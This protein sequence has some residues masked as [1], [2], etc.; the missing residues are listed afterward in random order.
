MGATKIL[1]KRMSTV[2]DAKNKPQKI[3][4]NST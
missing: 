1:L 2:K 4:E 3:R